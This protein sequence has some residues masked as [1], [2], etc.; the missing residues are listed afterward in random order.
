MKLK[1]KITYF[2]KYVF[3]HPFRLINFL[4]IKISKQLK[5]PH[6][7]GLPLTIMIE[8]TNLCNLKCP[9]C[10]TG[11]GRI[12]REKGNMEYSHFR[13]IIDEITPYS[14]HVRLWNWGEPL[15]N[16]KIFRMIAYAKKKNLFVNLS[17]NSNFLDKDVSEKILKSGLDELIISLDGASEET[18]KKYRKGGDF[19]KVIN[20]IKFL[21]SRKRKSDIKMPYV[22]LQFII[23][24]HNEHEIKNIKNL[25]EEIG[26]DELVFKT[27]G[28]MDYFSE[29]DIREYMPS[30]KKYSRYI[31]GKDEVFSKRAVKNK[32]DFLWEEIVI[33]WD[34]SVVPCCFDMNNFFVFG[35]TFSSSVREIWNNSKYTLFRKKILKEK[36]SIA[37]CRNCPGSNKETFV[38]VK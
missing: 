37:L 33:N 5:L 30:D 1:Q 14:F 25:A 7:F 31:I 24:K 29:E 2:M 32:C 23:M 9:L 6:V 11:A 28:I 26:V 34:G 38:N 12:K 27:V 8:P 20:S 35:N 3:L 13:K 36:E 22:K 4:K 10:P 21:T 19:Q 16:K 15:L 18:Y 17:T